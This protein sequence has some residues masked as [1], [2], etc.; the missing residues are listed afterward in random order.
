MAEPRLT[1]G[2]VDRSLG[3]STMHSMSHGQL[4]VGAP[5]FT[6]G[7][8]DPGT[9]HG[10]SRV[11]PTTS[12]DIPS[13]YPR[14][15]TSLSSRTLVVCFASEDHHVSA[16]ETVTPQTATTS[17]LPQ[18]GLLIPVGSTAAHFRVRPD[19]LPPPTTS[20]PGAL[21]ISTPLVPISRSSPNLPHIPSFIGGDQQDGDTFE[22]WLEEFESVAGIA[23]WDRR[24]KLVYLIVALKGAAKTYQLCTP[25]QKNDYTQLVA[26]LKKRFIPVVL[27]AL[28]TQMFHSR[29]QGPNES[30]DDFVQELCRLHTRA[31]VTAIGASPE[32]EKVVQKVLVNHFVSGLRCELQAKLVGVDGAMDELVAKACF[33]ETKRKELVATSPNSLQKRGFPNQG[34]LTLASSSKPQQPQQQP[35]TQNTDSIP[36]PGTSAAR[37]SNSNSQESRSKRPTGGRDLKCFR[38]GLLDTWPVSVPTIGG[39]Q[40]N[41]KPLETAGQSA[42]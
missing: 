26:A 32:A 3:D 31:Y 19:P 27:T 4:D 42:T 37:E 5:V 36:T 41:K 6:S 30:V 29:R 35:R 1:S 9:S 13:S 39:G 10:D 8:L 21:P 12:L 22:D 24:F 7:G 34:G 16:A 15:S 14:P 38:C 25:V 17:T 11:L 2:D 20:T 33:E 28:Q 23:G 40:R 18:V